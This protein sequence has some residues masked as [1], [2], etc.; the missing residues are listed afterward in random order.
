[1]SVYTVLKY[2]FQ[3][4]LLSTEPTIAIQGLLNLLAS[5]ATFI[6][7]LP[8]NDCSSSLPSPVIT[9]SAVLIFCSSPH[10][11]DI[12]SKPPSILAPKYSDSQ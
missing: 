7:A 12:K 2:L 10:N 9:R 6:G 11:F 1:V 8:H 4:S 5:S 3:L